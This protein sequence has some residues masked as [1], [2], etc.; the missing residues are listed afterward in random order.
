MMTAR[1]MLPAVLLAAVVLYFV[2]L[3]DST[4]WDA[5]ETFY[6]ETP[7]QMIAR[8]DYVIPM[9]NDE[10]R[11]NKPVLSYW[12]VAALY[13]LFDTSV[14]VQRVG[15][16]IGG[17]LIIACAFVLGHLLTLS[18][19]EER[20]RTLAA[21]PALLAAAGLAVDPRFLMFSRRIF[22]DIWIAAFMALTL[23]CFALSERF[24]ERRRVYLLLMYV[25]VGLGVLTK[26]PI[27]ALLPGLVFAVYLIVQRELR[28][29]TSMMIVPGILIVAAIVVPWYYALYQRDGWTYIQSFFIGENL[30]RYT[31]GIGQVT[32]RPWYFY[33]PSLFG[34]FFPLSLFLV[35][36]AMVWW[37]SRERFLTLLWLWV[38]VIVLFF[39]L[40]H[41]KQDLYILPIAPAVTALGAIAIGRHDETARVTRAVALAVGVILV[42]VGAAILALF[43]M[44]ARIYEIQGASALGILALAGGAAVVVLAARRRI[45]PAVIA[46]LL[47]LLAID[48]VFV[49]RVLPDFERYKPVAPLSEYLAPRL[50]PGDRVGHFHVGFPSMV[51]YLQRRVDPYYSAEALVQAMRSPTRVYAVLPERDY[52][53]LQPELGA[54]TCVLQREPTFEVKLRNIIRRA[55]LPH[56]VLVTNVC[57][58]AR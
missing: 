47:S 48:W 24:P 1:W 17:L 46:V 5:N 16:A 7:R 58:G 18:L 11:L 8:G 9:F 32:R 25:S 51:H 45:V 36:A 37:K 31:S 27:A 56:V 38:A 10:P 14:A 33:L 42:L 22:I 21:S 41:D 50:Q 40:S 39:S 49:L 52:L 43:G 28:R 26:G 34:D 54:T 15:I 6:V 3:G 20:R 35:S 23:T 57:E 55:P 30:G 44:S 4:I 29:T 2:G 13:H 19:P 53:G 12:M